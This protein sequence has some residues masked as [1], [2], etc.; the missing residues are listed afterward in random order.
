[1]KTKLFSK[2]AGCIFAVLIV[3]FSQLTAYCENVNNALPGREKT[4]Q[5]VDPEDAGKK[6]INLKVMSINLRHNSDFWE[7][8]FPLVADEI[9]RLKPDLIGIQE[10]AIGINQTR[11]LLRLIA[12]RDP[13]GELKYHFYEHLKYGPDMIKGEGVTILSRF[14]ISKKAAVDLGN[15]RPAVFA[16]VV[17]EPGIAIDFYN[18]HLH[19]MGGDEVRF[20]QA[21]KLVAFMQDNYAG[22][23]AF[24]TGDMNA[25]DSSQTIKYFLEEGKMIDTYAAL[26]GGATKPEDMTSPI[27]LMKKNVPQAPRNRIDY[28]F[29][30][31]PAGADNRLKIIDSIVCLRNARADGL[32]PS[33]HLG[34]MTTFQLVY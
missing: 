19:H 33:D 34:V 26:K 16:R 23:F 6:V 30:L 7:E 11:T 12:E 10:M 9:V 21:Q 5:C 2:L 20:P 27:I 1:M 29:A 15:S 28:V 13:A 4:P 17:P 31:P 18:T 8:R 14:P 3:S 22:N 32:Y 24:L 25:A